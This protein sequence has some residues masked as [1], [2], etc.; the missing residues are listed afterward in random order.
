[1]KDV[2][3]NVQ[4]TKYYNVL[5][6]NM[7]KIIIT[8]MAILLIT[9]VATIAWNPNPTYNPFEV[10]WNKLT[11]MSS[12]I[13]QINNTMT[14]AWTDEPNLVI[15]ENDVLI[16]GHL[17]LE[18]GVNTSA[19]SYF[20][21]GIYVQN[22]K[23][24]EDSYGLYVHL[25]T[26]KSDYSSSYGVRSLAKN[27]ASNY[28]VYSVV[29]G[30][31]SI[32]DGKFV[33]YANFG[34]YFTAS[35]GDMNYGGLFSAIGGN[36]NYAAHFESWG[37]TLGSTGIYVY[38][39]STQGYAGTFFGNLRVYGSC[40]GCDIAE[41]MSTRT[42]FNEI[43]CDEDKFN[44]YTSEKLREFLNNDPEEYEIYLRQFCSVPE[45][46][47]EFESGDVVC[48]DDGDVE[49]NFIRPCN[50]AY[51]KAAISVV[52]Y[53]ATQIIGRP[54]YPYPVSLAGNVPVKVICD[55]PIEIGDSLVSADRPGYAMKIDISDVDSFQE[56]QNRNDAVFAKAMT[57]CESGEAIIR[58]WI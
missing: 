2:L 18:G 58:A 24:E 51:D 27:S 19:E 16:K 20:Q 39:P 21:E 25:N 40:T 36:Y 22:S 26:T 49:K 33:N 28:G 46:F 43:V 30:V 29:P 54:D 17:D 57:S 44:S 34:G 15:T 35:N 45:E 10:L 32:D 47:I 14:R 13:V 50:G 6:N 8:I 55:K 7:K 37:G 12:T 48:I 38:T 4:K 23:T 53:D 52:N 31:L 56:F 9:S 41:K 1:M 5:V 11:D 42:A 3:K